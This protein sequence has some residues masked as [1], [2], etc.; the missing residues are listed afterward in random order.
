MEESTGFK[1]MKKQWLFFSAVF[2]FL[3]MLALY[4]SQ[5][6]Y[7]RSEGAAAFI[8]LIIALIFWKRS[9]RAL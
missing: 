7:H 8:L 9:Q 6:A 4:L 5:Q 1:I 3:T 2:L